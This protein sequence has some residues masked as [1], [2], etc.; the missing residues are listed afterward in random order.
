MPTAT[1]A[2]LAAIQEFL[3]INTSFPSLD[4]RRAGV[5]YDFLI[6]IHAAARGR[7]IDGFILLLAT[8]AGPFL[9]RYISLYRPCAMLAAHHS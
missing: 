3:L 9:C 5:Q 7:Q 6:S 2:V 4:Y 1:V 8:R